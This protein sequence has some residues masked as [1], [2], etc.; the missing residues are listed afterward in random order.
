MSGRFVHLHTHSHYSLLDGAASPEALV[1]RAADLGMPALALTDHDAMFGAVRYY[2]AAKAAGIHPVIGLE[3]CLGPAGH[4]V[5]LLAENDTGYRNLCRLSTAAMADGAGGGYERSGSGFDA[6]RGRTGRAV[7]QELLW[8]FGDGLIVL[9]GCRH[10][11]IASLLAAGREEDARQV[12]SGYRE[13][14][15]RNGFFIELQ[16]HG[17][18]GQ[19]K[20]NE[21]LLRLADELELGVVATNNVHYVERS[22]AE[23]HDALLALGAGAKLAD[24]NRLR[25][26]TTEFFMKS[27]VEMEA[28]FR[29][30]PD[31]L[32][33]TVRIAERCHVDVQLGRMRLPKLHGTH[34]KAALVDLVQRGARDRFGPELPPAVT[35]RLDHEL[36]VIGEAGLSDYFLLVADIVQRARE[37]DIPI[38]PGRGS[39]AGS[40]VAYCLHITDVDPLAHG[41]VFERFL[42]PERM[43]MPD[44]DVDVC[45]TRRD[46]LLA[47]VRK[48]YGPERV[49][50]IATFGTLAARAAIRDM[51]RVLDVPGEVVDRLARLIPNE[52]N[53]TLAEAQRRVPE[54]AR[55][56]STDSDADR[57]LTLAEAV[58]GT[59]RH[60]SVHAAGI[61][62]G[63]EALETELPLV[64]TLDGVRVTQ[65]PMED[66]EALGFV[67]MDLLGLR[68]LTVI[69]EAKKLAAAQGAAVPDPVPG[70][71]PAV[72]AAMTKFGTEGI[73][74][75]ET[76]MFQRLVERLKPD[77]FSDLVALVALGRPG[78]AERIDDFIRRRHGRAPVRYHHPS[79]EPILEETYGI[80]VYQEQVIRIAVDVAGYSP[81][82]ADLFRRAM[83]AKQADVLEAQRDRFVAGAVANGVPDAVARRIFHEVETF[84]G[85]G[86]NKSHSVAY[87]LLCYETAYLRTHFPAA[88]FAALLSSWRGHQQRIA[89]YVAAARAMGVRVLK[90]DVNSSPVDF[91]VADGAVAFGLEGI[92]HV[93]RGAAEAI[94]AARQDGP[95]ASIADLAQR[96]P[97]RHAHRRLFQSLIE[98]GA[99]DGLG[100]S[101]AQMIHWLGSDTGPG[102]SGRAFEAV[103]QTS[104]FGG[105]RAH[106]DISDTIGEGGPLIITVAAEAAGRFIGLRRLLREH[107]GPVPVLLRVAVADQF[108]TV[109][110]DDLTVTPSPVLMD[111]L[112]EAVARGWLTDARR[113]SGASIFRG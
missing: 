90:P 19:R 105:G 21:Q 11:V 7:T 29:H 58:E 98:A 110:P 39:A 65:Y 33:N 14:F 54:L 38:G 67:K 94:V 112:N 2:R 10:G 71:D 66:V 8:E 46:E 84:A 23:A 9:S 53:M 44:I 48:R 59:P 60:L 109:Q 34:S 101:R 107:P 72:Y 50:H 79:L 41:L 103:G 77:R 78:P 1:E 56:R 36:T 63:E 28:L 40:L 26:G 30:R 80:I 62:I 113:G 64:T 70:D 4:H 18:D 20:L 17:I 15:G 61:V 87:A 32:E 43:Q 42:N 93:G 25:F 31:A 82:E 85:Y 97:G 100:E 99:C 27:A 52:P 51:G 92:P 73:F 37:L 16:D 76:P 108:V 57:L 86:F 83:S 24:T 6:H 45:D 88:Y 12:A 49:A 47:D 22:D 96:L 5:T 13:R 74:Q 55:V 3:L 106:S 95:F 104:L 35:D 81:A 91:S 75:L 102:G 111:K 68:T 89:R 69:D